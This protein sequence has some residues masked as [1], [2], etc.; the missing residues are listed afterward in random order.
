MTVNEMVVD[1]GTSQQL[2]RLADTV[3]RKIIDELAVIGD[4]SE[5]VERLVQYTELGTTHFLIRLL[6][7]NAQRDANTFKEEVIP[8][9]RDA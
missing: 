5:I 6:G 1:S 2:E 3:P 4:P 9:F 7:D 8:H